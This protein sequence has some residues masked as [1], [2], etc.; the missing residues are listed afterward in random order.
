MPF[1]D[2]SDVL[3]DPDFCDNSLICQRNVLIT[4]SNGRGSIVPHNFPFSAVVTSNSGERLRRGVIGEH[5]TDNITV[6]TRFRLID[7]GTGQTAD[8]V[9]WSGK[10]YTVT[11][12]NDYTTY[13]IGFVEAVCEMIPL[14]G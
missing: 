13:G 3:L 7:A 2:V 10:R 5:A 6:I 14:A 11:Q 9:Q 8:I 4:D 1:L 12:V